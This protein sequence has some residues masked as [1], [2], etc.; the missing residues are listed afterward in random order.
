MKYV[1]YGWFICLLVHTGGG[2]AVLAQPPLHVI[3]DLSI[4]GGS[5]TDSK[6]V[7]ERDGQKWRGR[8]GDDPKSFTELEC[9]H[10]YVFTF[11]KKGYV[12]K[13]IF[14]STKV[15]EN[16]AKSGFKSFYFEVTLF[17]QV[18]GVDILIFN[19][20]VAKI[21]YNPEVGDFTYDTDY[22]SS[23]LAALQKAE[24]ELKQKRKEV[25]SNAKSPDI[26]PAKQEK[27]LEPVSK[28][29]ITSVDSVAKGPEKREENSYME[30]EKRVTQITVTTHG[31][32]HVYKKVA[33]VWG[34]YYFCDNMSIT[35]SSY[36]QNA[37]LK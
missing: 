33:Y 16:T 12:T 25:K 15:P 28:K 9:Q 22:S 23:I 18:D 6:I 20:P 27:V 31:K 11:S 29:T 10:D 17:R 2:F 19:Q 4:D 3:S 5:K 13:K 34:V 26:I 35:E 32:S 8:N 30:G 36:I 24:K 14:I 37:L 21:I 7:I 1:L